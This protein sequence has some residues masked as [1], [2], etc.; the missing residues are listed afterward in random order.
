MDIY[1]EYALLKLKEKEL[2]DRL[3][4]MEEALF[5]DMQSKELDS[6]KTDYGTFSVNY[7]KNWDYPE[8]IAQEEEELKMHKKLVQLNG[9]AKSYV[10]PY[11]TFRRDKDNS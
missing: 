2:K 6:F 3:K 10:N 7:R 9:L 5:N 11:V 8:E 4:T 1:E